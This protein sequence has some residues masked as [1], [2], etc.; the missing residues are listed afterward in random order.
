[1]NA[2][3]IINYIANAEKKTP[4]WRKTLYA[5]VALAVVVFA[6]LFFAHKLPWQKSQP[7]QQAAVEQCDGQTVNTAET[8]A[9]TVCV[10][11]KAE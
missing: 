2:Q 10:E 9:D 5:V 1:M 7:E 4:V 3:E 6:V 8:T 11:A